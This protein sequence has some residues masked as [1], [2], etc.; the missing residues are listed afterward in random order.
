[1]N[2]SQNLVEKARQARTARKV[3]QHKQAIVEIKR[4]VIR[5]CICVDGKNY[6]SSA[7]E[8]L[9]GQL[10]NVSFIQN[11]GDH[12]EGLLILGDVCNTLQTQTF[13]AL[14]S[15]KI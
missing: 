2:K 1:M 14:E 15:P 3:A 9:E 8:A 13:P 6:C 5:G 7:L 4:Q 10:V 11:D 12:T